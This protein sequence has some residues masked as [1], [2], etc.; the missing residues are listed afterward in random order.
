[1]A[2]VAGLV[3]DTVEVVG[4]TVTDI[5]LGASGFADHLLLPLEHVMR[6]VLR[7]N[8]SVTS[9]FPPLAAQLINVW[10]VLVDTR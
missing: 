8:I 4:E 7:G 2:P 1:M 9:Q 6:L 10:V 5:A 3:A